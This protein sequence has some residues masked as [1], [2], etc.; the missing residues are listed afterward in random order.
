MENTSIAA[1]SSQAKSKLFLIGL[2]FLIVI[3]G[4]LVFMALSSMAKPPE[5]KELLSKAPIIEVIAVKQQ[6]VTF[7]IS[8]QGTVVPRTETI[9]TSEVSGQITFVSKKFLVGGYFEQGELMLK[10]DPIS[11]EV[12]VLQAESR[13]GAMQAEMIQ[14][15][16]RAEQAEDE[17]LLTGKTV[18]E[19]PILALRLPQLQ[20]AQADVKAAA[21]DLQEAKIKLSRT[22]IIA[23]YDALIREKQV[24]IGQYVS[25]GSQLATTIAID[26]AE[27]RLPI[28]QKD[29]AFI[30]LPK[31]N[32]ANK[33]QTIVEIYTKQ[34]GQRSTWQST[35]HRYEGVVDQ[36]S[37]VHYVVAQI[38]D[39]Y[40]LKDTNAID[41]ELRVGTFVKANVNGKSVE[42]LLPIPRIALRGIN[43]LHLVNA[44]NKLHILD[45]DVVR[46]EKDI[47]FI[48]ANITDDMRIITTKLETP[49]EGMLLRV[50][51][52]FEINKPEDLVSAV[53]EVEG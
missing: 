46:A 50:L 27:V 25:T 23:P 37:R 22:T 48:N 15:H 20:K 40:N 16:A 36:Q 51:G 39:P 38:A 41:S 33:E 44:E 8:S 4:A 1:T 19:A 32:K 49:V 11:Y 18:E 31:I 13:L 28:K 47:V 2:P 10:I 21:A 3:V 43:Q 24:D 53:D 9:L 30:N 14:E 45:I 17:W 52:E 42:G 29:I 34:G 12:A 26:Y 7:A 6:N 5:K 35:I